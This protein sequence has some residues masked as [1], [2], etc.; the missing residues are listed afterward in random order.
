MVEKKVKKPAKDSEENDT[1]ATVHTY[2]GFPHK[3]AINPY[4]F[5]RFPKRMLADLGWN[6]EMNVVIEKNS[7][8]SITI[9]RAQKE[10]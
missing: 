4:C 5:L 1:K 10:V 6:P 9:Q 3:T 2:K 7:D 8:G